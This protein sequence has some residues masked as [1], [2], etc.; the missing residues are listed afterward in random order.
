VNISKQDGVKINNA[1]LI[2]PDVEALNGLIH[3]I[4]TVLMP[5]TAAKA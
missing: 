5:R 1:K 3:L 4:D 2:V